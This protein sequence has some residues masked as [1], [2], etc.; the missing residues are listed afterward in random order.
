MN[1]KIKTNTGLVFSWVLEPNKTLIISGLVVQE[2]NAE[3][4]THPDQ[5]VRL[6]HNEIA[7]VKEFKIGNGKWVKC[8]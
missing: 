8:R 1:G 4:I 5:V 3:G 6:I 7:E 2:F